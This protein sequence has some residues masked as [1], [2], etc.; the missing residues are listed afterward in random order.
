MKVFLL[1][2]KDYFALV[3]LLLCLIVYYIQI[4]FSKK[5]P[6]DL[7]VSQFCINKQLWCLSYKCFILSIVS[8][9]MIFFCFPLLPENDIE[10]I[11]S[12]SF[13]YGLRGLYSISP[14]VLYIGNYIGIVFTRRYYHMS[15]LDDHIEIQKRKKVKIKILYKDIESVKKGRNEYV[16]KM[17]KKTVPIG[18]MSLILYNNYPTLKYKLD[19]LAE[20]YIEKEH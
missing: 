7:G 14:L 19:K 1:F 2:V 6:I 11:A 5:Q 10:K 18:R 20:K 16:I 8:G 15:I 4:L 9:I 3:I 13:P 12:G 17:A